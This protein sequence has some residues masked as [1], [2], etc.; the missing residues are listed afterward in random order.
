MHPSE[1][2]PQAASRTCY[3]SP[4]AWYGRDMAWLEQDWAHRFGEHEIA[5]IE[6]AVAQV[7]ARGRVLTEVARDDFALPH[8]SPLLES[9]RDDVL[10]AR[11]AYEDDP[12]P[13]HKRHLLRLWLSTPTAPLSAD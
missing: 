6:A 12:E 10:H 2:Q 1:L 7:L 4:A 3:E 9:I 8:T 11:T 13:E 5:E